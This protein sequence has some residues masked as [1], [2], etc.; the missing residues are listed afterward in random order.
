MS[1]SIEL[2]E[3]T[4]FIKSL[5]LG[6]TDNDVNYYSNL[7]EN[8]IQN[9]KNELD[10]HL[11]LQNYINHGG[12]FGEIQQ[13]KKD[14]ETLTALLQNKNKHFYNQ[15]SIDLQSDT[16]EEEHEF[17]SSIIRDFY[18]DL[19]KT[20]KGNLDFGCSSNRFIYQSLFDIYYKNANCSPP[21]IFVKFIQPLPHEVTNA[22]LLE[23]IMS[24]KEIDF[25]VKFNNED[26]YFW[27]TLAKNVIQRNVRDVS[28]ITILKVT[29][30]QYLKDIQILYQLKCKALNKIVNPYSMELITQDEVN[31]L[32]WATSEHLHHFVQHYP[33]HELSRSVKYLCLKTTSAM[34]NANIDDLPVNLF[35]SD[36]QNHLATFI[37]NINAIDNDIPTVNSS[38]IPPKTVDVLIRM[39]VLIG[40]DNLWIYG[41]QP[42][43]SKEHIHV[44]MLNDLLNFRKELKEL[45]SIK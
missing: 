22:E 15:N 10:A 26:T 21:Q 19:C 17:S 16:I 39:L 29:P 18:K 9:V 27:F 7:T 45:K 40:K 32:H 36:I 31:P 20:C 44:R 24:N 3:I 33:G 30:T 4:Q 14:L 2:S 25:T 23:T 6:K 41:N 13:I 35:D 37:K 34:L 11:N 12:L 38:V 28:P 1:H 5:I 43:E 8:I 42:F